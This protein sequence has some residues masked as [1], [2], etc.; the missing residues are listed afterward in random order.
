MGRCHG[1]W[2]R[3][4]AKARPPALDV[5]IPRATDQTLLPLPGWP[6][7]SCRS[8][9]M[10]RCSSRPENLAPSVYLREESPRVMHAK[11]TLR[12][13]VFCPSTTR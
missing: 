12:I 13:G 2:Y 10:F 1:F 4:S 6:R 5:P 8:P 9:L 3:F 11:S 7:R